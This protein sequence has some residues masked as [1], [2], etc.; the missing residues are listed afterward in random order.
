MKL[1][2]DTWLIL[3]RQILLILRNPTWLFVPFM[4]SRTAGNCTTPLR[5]HPMVG[6]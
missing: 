2:R 5:L 1:L 4:L 6:N 3:Q